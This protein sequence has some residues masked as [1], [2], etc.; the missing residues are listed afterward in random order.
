MR[1]LVRGGKYLVF[2]GNDKSLVILLL[3]YSF[4]DEELL[5]SV[6]IKMVA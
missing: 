3:S 1:G 6:D 4:L 2:V 5:I